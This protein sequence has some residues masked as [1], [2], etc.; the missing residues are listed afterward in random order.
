MTTSKT[1]TRFVAL[2]ELL[3]R[4]STPLGELLATTGQMD[5]DVGGSEANVAASL[6]TLGHGC[7]LISAVPDTALGDAAVIAMRSRGV[8]CSAILRTP[9]RM[10][11]Y[12]LERGSGRRSADVIYDRA[13]SSFSVLDAKSIDWP[14]LLYGA[15]R[16]HLSGITI[17]LG[18]SSTELALAAAAA[19]TASGIPVSFDCNYRTH[20]WSAR[21]EVSLAPLIELVSRA[22]ILFGNHRDISLFL[23]D[24]L[25]GDT[26]NRRRAAAEAAFAAFPKLRLIAATTRSIHHADQ[27]GLSARVDTPESG[28]ETE[29][30]LVPHIVDRIGTGD[31]F[32]AGILHAVSERLPIDIIAD[33]GL[34]LGV[35]KHT[36]KGDTA[37]Y[38]RRHLKRFTLTAGDVSR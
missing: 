17:A 24:T 3:L 22:D 28:H 4:L 20:L 37:D 8:D 6:A 29:T 5:L 19:A 14:T 38:G 21:G 2:G 9:G 18:E 13:G 30:V 16:L 36:V 27:H 12:W 35:L 32:A 23:G 7:A 11:L 25:Q 26:V 31:A 1:Y 33:T 34:A 15:D 10:G